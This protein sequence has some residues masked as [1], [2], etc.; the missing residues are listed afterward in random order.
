MKFLHSQKNCNGIDTTLSCFKVQQHNDKSAVID[1]K[2]KL[3]NPHNLKT[4]LK[5]PCGENWGKVWLSEIQ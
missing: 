4:S 5:I 1:K 3:A 2:G